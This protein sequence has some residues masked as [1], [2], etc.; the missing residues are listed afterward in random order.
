MT[1]TPG[2]PAV[3]EQFEAIRIL[4]QSNPPGRWAVKDSFN[5][6]DLGREGFDLLFEASWI[7]NIMPMDA[8]SSDIVWTRET[9]GNR[10][11][12]FADPDFAMFTGR[13]GFA[14]VAGG[15]LYRAEGV[16]GISNV[17]AEAAD[18]VSVWRSLALLATKTFPRLPL[19][20]YESG[21]ELGAALDAGFEAGDPLRVWVKS[22]D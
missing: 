4:G 12:P 8:A 13:R 15:T 20:G 5:S 10:P 1:L 22:A 9:S 19:V 17:V 21:A 16:V 14:I 18:A 7:R 6:L 2:E 3:A 11:F